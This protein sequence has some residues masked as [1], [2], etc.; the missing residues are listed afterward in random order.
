MGDGGRADRDHAAVRAHAWRRIEP[1]WLEE[2]GAHLVKR[3]HEPHWEKTRAQVVAF[4]RGTLYG[5]WSTPSGA[6]T[7]GR[8]I[9]RAREMFIRA[10]LVEGE[11][12]TRAPF[13]AHNRQADARHRALE[14][15]SR[16]PDVLVDDELIFAFYDARVPEGHHTTA[17]SSKVAQGGGARRSEAAV[18]EERGPDAPRG[19]GHHHRAISRTSCRSARTQ[20][21]A[22]LPLRARSRVDGVTLTVPLA[23][24]NQVPPRAANGW[25]R[26][27]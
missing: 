14:H 27:C 6:C 9:R 20:L 3:H 25:C 19:G 22:R 1:G 5:L 23:L 2:I 13:F 21:R 8:S 11:F 7:T 17:P 24:L 12:E 26:A 15:K 4:E 18:P 16:R 10:A